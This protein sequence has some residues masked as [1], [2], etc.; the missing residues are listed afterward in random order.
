VLHLFKRCR[1]VFLGVAAPGVQLVGDLATDAASAEDGG[2]GVTA[3]SAFDAVLVPQVAAHDEE[4]DAGHDA[5]QQP[6]EAAAL[7]HAVR[8]LAS[9]AQKAK[10]S[11]A[12]V[13]A[14]S[15]DAAEKAVLPVLSSGSAT[16]APLSLSFAPAFAFA[17][18][19][20][21]LCN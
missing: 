18:L 21:R 8:I 6:V 19:L 15:A 14:V 3:G 12:A 17:H 4:G 2:G 20:D 7:A 11:A 16:A 5:S 9:L 10:R 13:S 1:T